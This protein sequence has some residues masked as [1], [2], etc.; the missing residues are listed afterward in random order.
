MFFFET[1][2]KRRVLQVTCAIVWCLFSGGPIFGFAA[3]KP[4]LVDQHIYES[5]CFLNATETHAIESSSVAFLTNLFAENSNVN[6]DDMTIQGSI[7]KCSAQDLKLNLMFTVGAVLTNVS[8]LLIG[9]IL[10]TYG[11]RVCGLIGAT[12]LFFACFVFV[13]ASSIELF[14]PYLVGYASMALGG[15][16]A[17]ISSFQLSNAFPDKSGT[18]LALLTGAFDASSSVFLFYRIFYTKFEGSF[19]LSSFFKIYLIVPIFMTIVQIFI[20]P[21]ESYLTPPPELIDDPSSPVLPI[22]NAAAAEPSLHERTPLLSSSNTDDGYASG[23]LQ[24]NAEDDFAPPPRP[25]G[26]RSSLGDAMKTAYVEEELSEAKNKTSI[27]GILHGFPASYQFKTWWFILMCSFTTVQ[28]L[29]LNYF[30]ATIN[31]Q[32]T[33]LLNSTKKA[34]YLNKFF[35]IALPLGGIISIPFVGLF[36]D[37]C[38]TFIVLLGLLGVSMIIGIL[39]VIPNLLAG[40]INVMFFV[41]YRPFFYTSVSDYC[42]KVFGFETFGTVY[43]TIMT[44][45]GVVNF[46]QTFLDQAT[47]TTFKMNPTPLNLVMLF[48]TLV[49]GGITVSY[50]YVQSKIYTSK[51]KDLSP[52]N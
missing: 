6:N 28:M 1:P 17:Y 7:A 20:M 19:S 42:A 47:H 30:V 41:A 15:P 51:K 11:P 24:D 5:V 12:F 49:L 16:F 36:L 45:S 33:Y 31:S 39:G 13:N 34:D 14:D 35:D 44:I 8:A 26:R 52:S 21:N 48:V 3:L 23:A 4:V 43:G 29:R 46:G 10:D 2:S 25:T 27:F 40:F 18:V 9:R 32:Y 22:A 38:T 37:N 50:V